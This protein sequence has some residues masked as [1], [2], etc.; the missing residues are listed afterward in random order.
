[1]AQPTEAFSDSDQPW[2]ADVVDWAT[3]S[4]SFKA[5]I[6]AHKLTIQASAG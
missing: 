4:E 2:R 5:L 6:A 3:T 1:M